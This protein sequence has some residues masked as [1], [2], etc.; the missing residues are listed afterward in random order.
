MCYTYQSNR[1]W[2]AIKFINILSI[3]KINFRENVKLNGGQLFNLTEMKVDGRNGSLMNSAVGRPQ[4]VVRTNDKVP[5]RTTNAC[6][7][8]L[9]GA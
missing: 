2:T 8:K 7:R 5:S 9:S 3:V 6:Q 4:L 1:R